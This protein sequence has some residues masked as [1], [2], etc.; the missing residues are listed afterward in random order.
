MWVELAIPRIE[1]RYPAFLMSSSIFMSWISL[2]NGVKMN[3]FPGCE[4]IE[5]T[6]E[7]FHGPI[8][9]TIY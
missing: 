5:Y 1:P 6:L 2:Q 7:V 3:R 9:R 4:W 8:N